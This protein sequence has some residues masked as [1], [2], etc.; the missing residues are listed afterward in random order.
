MPHFVMTELRCAGLSGLL[1]AG[2]FAAVMS[3]ID[4]GINSLT[5]VVVYDWLGGRRVPLLASRL[6]C[7]LFGICVIAAA[8][9]APYLDEH[10]ID[11]ISKIAGSFLG[12]LLGVFLL[13]LL[14]P[15]GNTAGALIG[16]VAGSI[17]LAVVWRYTDVAA[18]WYGAF[19]CVP[20]LVAG[21]LASSL[22]VVVDDLVGRRAP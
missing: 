13:G 8:L 14:V 1:L 18:G 2:L 4:S 19:T 10:V 7:L 17:S 16:L 20:V 9:L 21:T 6:L 15:R 12:L 11:I 22:V 3:T 5:A